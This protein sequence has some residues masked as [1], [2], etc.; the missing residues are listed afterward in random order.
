[1]RI[2]QLEFQRLAPAQLSDLTALN[3]TTSLTVVDTRARA[4]AL[5]RR[6]NE[7]DADLDALA[8]QALDVFA[9]ANLHVQVRWLGYELGGYVEDGEAQPLHELLGLAPEHRLVTQVNAYRAQETAQGAGEGEQARLVHFFVE[10]V[11]E[12]M[13]AQARVGKLGPSTK[14]IRL[15]FSDGSPAA[16]FS[17]DVFERILLGLRATLHLELTRMSG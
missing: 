7:S 9:T 6:L 13:S 8:R 3:Q 17:P 4:Q 2:D 11:K 14:S 5:R 10:P 1:M 15:E 12:L 16:E